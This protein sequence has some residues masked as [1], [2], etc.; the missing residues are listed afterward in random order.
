MIALKLAFREL[1][2]NKK[3][4]TFFTANLCIGL[5]GFTFIYFF[6]TNI[7]GALEGRA[8]TLLSSDLAIFGRRVLS[9]VEKERVDK[10]L[11]PKVI[12]ESK[13]RELYSMARLEENQ[14]SRSRLVFIKSLKDP[15][16]LIGEISLK[17]GKKI[18]KEFIDNLQLT[19]NVVISP[20]VAH[21]FKVD[22]GSKF[23]LGSQEFIV[24][25]VIESDS[26][27][28][29]RGVSLAPKVYIGDSFLKKT[30]LI[31]LSNFCA[32]AMVDDP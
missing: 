2:N 15:Y 12:Q 20:E 21:Q 25:E 18:D 3:Y 8:K 30:N 7:T 27:S 29:L 24:S 32:L 14:E 6:R 19:P 31:V 5:I 13:L 1:K 23:W 22:I 16:P 11:K 9:G 4:W 17:G 26:T 28:S 10:F